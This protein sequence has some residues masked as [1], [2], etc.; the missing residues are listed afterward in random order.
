[1]GRHR[2]RKAHRHRLLPR[3]VQRRPHPDP[4]RHG[5]YFQLVF[6]HHGQWN[7]GANSNWDV[8]PWNTAAGGFLK[9]PKEFF[10]KVIE[11]RSARRRDER[12]ASGLASRLRAARQP[13]GTAESGPMEA[14]CAKL[15]DRFL[16]RLP[17]V[18]GANAPLTICCRRIRDGCCNKICQR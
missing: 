17:M 14:Y 3:P 15:A 5:I 10:S 7:T 2:R 12:L 11:A 6:Q 16:P 13:V 8:N 1:M 9:S 18:V 4:R